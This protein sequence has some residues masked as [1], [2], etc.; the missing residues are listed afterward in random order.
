LNDRIS[1]LGNKPLNAGLTE[2]GPFAKLAPPSLLVTRA[3]P[4]SGPTHAQA[5]PHALSQ[6]GRKEE[7]DQP[8]PS[9]AEGRQE[10]GASL[11]GRRGP[12]RNDPSLEQE[13]D[14]ETGGQIVGCQVSGAIP[15]G[16]PGCDQDAA[17]D[18]QQ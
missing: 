11:L 18:R 2:T 16:D 14:Q 9:E 3:P 12:T 5:A 4:F 8:R 13:A 10:G 6:A 1:A 15:R 7:A 17:A